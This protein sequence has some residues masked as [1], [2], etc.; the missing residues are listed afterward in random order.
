LVANLTARASRRQ[1][2]LHLLLRPDL[3]S[4]V[5]RIEHLTINLNP[6]WGE[7][8]ES[9]PKF[10]VAPTRREAEGPQLN[11]HRW[12]R[13]TT[14]G[15]QLPMFALRFGHPLDPEDRLTG[16]FEIIL[17]GRIADVDVVGLYDPLGYRIQGISEQQDTVIRGTFDLSLAGLTYPEEAAARAEVSQQGAIPDH[18]LITRL[19]Q[20]LANE[21]YYVK[22]IEE[23]PPADSRAGAHIQLR[24]WDVKGRRYLGLQP[25]DFHLVITGE[26]HYEGGDL[27]TWGNTRVEITTQ[28]SAA[29]EEK[30]EQ[31]SK[32]A[33][34]IED[35]VREGLSHAARVPPPLLEAPRRP[36]EPVEAEAENGGSVDVEMIR[37]RLDQL[38]ELFME[39]KI[40]PEQYME[41]KDQYQRALERGRGWGGEPWQ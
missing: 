4:R 18:H 26:E 8:Q 40:T 21:G 35:L 34:Q 33:Q 11:V 37:Q 22:N 9:I 13:I 32:T 41:L 19:V 7:V 3:A 36:V 12:S 15:G 29:S 6:A 31:V 17:K 25:V 1:I 14:D 27:P 20:L 28:G 23:N 38:E 30:V 2:E 5:R 16:S 39:G 10:G 24:S